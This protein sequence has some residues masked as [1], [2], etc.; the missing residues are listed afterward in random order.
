MWG[1]LLFHILVLS[2]LDIGRWLA[3]KT[4]EG[5]STGLPPAAWFLPVRRE[6]GALKGN[7][8][9]VTLSS[10]TYE[11]RE[12]GWAVAFLGVSVFTSMKWDENSSYSTMSWGALIRE[13]SYQLNPTCN[14][15]MNVTSH[16][17]SGVILV[18]LSNTW[19]SLSLCRAR[20]RVSWLL[21][22]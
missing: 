12:L 1:F 8:V 15:S 20:D 18:I 16:Y 5:F 21:T 11:L 9:D 17:F 6:D 22:L 10:I 14:H 7:C 13:T 4:Y 19:A 2:A 3:V